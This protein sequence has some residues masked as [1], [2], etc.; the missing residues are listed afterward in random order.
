MPVEIPDFILK[1]MEAQGNVDPAEVAAKAAALIES[2]ELDEPEKP[3]PSSPVHSPERVDDGQ[4]S[5]LGVLAPPPAEDLHARQSDP[6]NSHSASDDVS[7]REGPTSMVN[8]GTHKH[9]I[10]TVYGAAER[11]L[12]DTEAWTRAGISARSGAWH[13][14]SDL[15][16]AGAIRHVRDVRDIETGSMVRTCAITLAGQAA[17]AKLENGKP[18]TVGG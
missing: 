12:T 10:L 3:A 14:C 13:R 18:V 16:D 9:R 8:P 11:P 5:L 4:E 17:L 1:A 15:L 2:G 6:A 7:G